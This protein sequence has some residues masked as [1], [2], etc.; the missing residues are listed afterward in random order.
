MNYTGNSDTLINHFFNMVLI[1]TPKFTLRIWDVAVIAIVILLTSVVLRLI[2]RAILRHD[3]IDKGKQYSL[4]SLSRY[5]IIIFVII[6]ILQYVGIKVTLL[7]GGSAALLVGVGL[8]LQNMFSDFVSGIILLMD[9]SIKVDDI[10]EVN[11][12]VC[13]VK[14][15][16]LRTTQVLTRDD[17]YI[18]LPN[19][20]LTKNNIINWTH[21]LE[22]SRFDV[23][24]GV[25]YDTD[26]QLVKQ[27]LLEVAKA[28]KEVLDDPKPFVRLINFGDSSVNFK[29]YFWTQNIFRVENVKSDIRFMIYDKFKEN[30]VEIPFP[31]HVIHKAEER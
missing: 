11:G 12:L 26:T 20:S 9:S 31:Q 18:L 28:H 6:W 5:I 10:I 1:E 15:I 22:K 2:K 17:K 14:R 30:R 25:A 27:L 3:T 21:N 16:K 8:G 19:S 13:Q 7:L 24:V 4:Y 23:D 29:L